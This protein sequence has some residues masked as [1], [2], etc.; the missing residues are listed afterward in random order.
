MKKRTRIVLASGLLLFFGAAAAVSQIG[1]SDGKKLYDHS[2]D[3]FVVPN[4][5]PIYTASPG[6]QQGAITT[7]GT[8]AYI[9]LNGVWCKITVATP[10]PTPTPT[11]TATATFTPTPTP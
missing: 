3:H 7:N 6:N 4:G 8:G 1:L 9:Y 5:Q 2:N 10:T 11:A